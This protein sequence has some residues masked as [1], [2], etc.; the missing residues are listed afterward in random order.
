LLHFIL[1]LSLPEAERLLLDESL[2]QLEARLRFLCDVGLAYL[3][4]DRK[5]PSLS[6]GEAQRIKLARQLG[7]SLTGVL[8]VLDEPTI[9]LHPHDNH[10]LNQALLKLKNLG[11][12]LLMVEHDPLTIE[13]AD[14]VLDFGPQSGALGGE[15][16]ARGTYKSLLKN[17]HSLTGAYLSGRKKVMDEPIQ[18]PLGKKSLRVKGAQVNN[19]KAVDVNFPLG[20]LTC[21]TGVSGSG[22]STLIHQVLTPALQRGIGF[23]AQIDYEGAR[24]TGMDAFRQLITIDQKP[25]GHTQRSDVGTY[26]DL[27]PRMREFFTQ[28]PGA[29][30]LGLQGKHFSPNHRAG[31]CTGCWGLGFK[32]VEMHFLPPVRITCPDCRGMRLNPRSLGV[33]YKGKHFGNYLKTTIDEAREV[34]EHIPRIRA[35]IDTLISVGLGYLHIGQGM[36]SLSGG[37]AQRIK[38]S[39]ELVKRQSGQTIYLMDE[40]TTGLHPDDIAKLLKVLQKLVD[41]G[42]TMI[43]IEHNLDFIA[44]ADYLVDLGPGPGAAGGEIIATGRPEEVARHDGSYTGQFLRQTL[45]AL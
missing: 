27:L 1:D 41:K 33:E 3:S 35:V 23:K 38:L 24:V 43:V 21:V 4:L 45:A 31:M 14:Y 26:C 39:R 44:Q 8:Y 25:I 9:G 36:A 32:R 40:P 2:K 10:R 11:N 34:F 12:T 37:E 22:K 5:A 15:I 29:A 6:G 30:A 19:L 42:N 16:T 13:M 17:K 7:S 18:R 28:L 20:N